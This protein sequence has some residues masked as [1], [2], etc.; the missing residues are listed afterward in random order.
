V[1]RLNELM[2]CW[3]RVGISVNGVDVLDETRVLCSIGLTFFA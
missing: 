2:F 3:I 1:L